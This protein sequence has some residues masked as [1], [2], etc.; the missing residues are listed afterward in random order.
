MNEDKYKFR[1]G[2]K[3]KGIIMNMV[4]YGLVIL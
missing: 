3:N 2:R 4:L 1:L